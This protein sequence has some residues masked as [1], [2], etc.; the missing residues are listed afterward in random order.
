VGYLGVV[1]RELV[2]GFVWGCWWLL[3][4]VYGLG[5]FVFWELGLSGLGCSVGFLLLW[6]SYWCMCVCG[7]GFYVV[8]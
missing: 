3:G 4:C 1:F 6:V 5:Y 7:L 8:I 2:I